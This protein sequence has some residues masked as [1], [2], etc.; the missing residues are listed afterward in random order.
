M[1]AE[2]LG[3][4]TGLCGGKCGSMHVTDASVGALGATGIVGASALLAIGAAGRRTATSLGRG[5]RGL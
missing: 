4:G 2:I 3:K 5:L 1:M